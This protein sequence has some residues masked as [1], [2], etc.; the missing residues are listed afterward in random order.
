MRKHIQHKIHNIWGT[1]HNVLTHKIK[2]THRMHIHTHER[3]RAHT[4]THTITHTY[5][6]TYLHTHARARARAHTHTTHIPRFFNASVLY[7]FVCI[8]LYIY[9]LILPVSYCQIFCTCMYFK[10]FWN[11]FFVLV[12]Q[13]LSKKYLY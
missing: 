4:S 9:K 2:H 8:R 11:K 12:F 13:I 1:A 10:Y 5:A 6:Q 3:A 7:C